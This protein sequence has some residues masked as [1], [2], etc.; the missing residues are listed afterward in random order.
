MYILLNSHSFATPIACAGRCPLLAAGRCLV[1]RRC[2]VAAP[3]R[4]R[5]SAA[6][7]RRSAG[8]KAALQAAAL[9]P[10]HA[11]RRAQSAPGPLG[12][13]RRLRCGA[14]RRAEMRIWRTTRGA[15][16]GPAPCEDRCALW[17]SSSIAVPTPVHIIPRV[18]IEL[19]GAFA[20]GRLQCCDAASKPDRCLLCRPCAGAAIGRHARTQPLCSKRRRICRLRQRGAIGRDDLCNIA[21]SHCAPP[22]GCSVQLPASHAVLRHGPCQ[23]QDA[24]HRGCGGPP[25]AGECWLQR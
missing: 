24:R 8:R 12:G 17:R 21:D 18:G 4:L 15:A 19:L 9:T 16:C 25:R 23:S 22:L 2:A 13:R 3:Y 5:R 1:T 10:W 11:Y 7:R 14:R 20:A 6:R